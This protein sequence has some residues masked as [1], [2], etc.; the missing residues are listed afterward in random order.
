MLALCANLV[1]AIENG[2][3]KI[4]NETITRLKKSLRLRISF[5]ITA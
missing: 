4:A 2:E 5:F 3:L 1:W